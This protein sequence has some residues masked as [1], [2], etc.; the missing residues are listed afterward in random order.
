ME[1]AS[2]KCL[3][4]GLCSSNENVMIDR[5]YRRALPSCYFCILINQESYNPSGSGSCTSS[6]GYVGS[7]DAC[8]TNG[9]IITGYTYYFGYLEGST[10]SA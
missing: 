4:N 8:L 2:Q 6:S 5:I 3:S 1:C 7:F 10:S 9:Y